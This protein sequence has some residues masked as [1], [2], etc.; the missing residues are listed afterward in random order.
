MYYGEIVWLKNQ[1]DTYGKLKVDINNPDPNKRS[2]PL[3]VLKMLLEFEYVGGINIY[4]PENDKTSI[5]KAEL[6]NPN[7]LNVR[8]YIGISIMGCTDKV[9]ENI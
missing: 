5:C 9:D 7:K 3:V 4:D 6:T 2:A 1:L 8:G